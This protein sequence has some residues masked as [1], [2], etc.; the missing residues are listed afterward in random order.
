MNQTEL[1]EFFCWAESVAGFETEDC[2]ES[3]H[4]YFNNVMVGGWAGDC[5]QF[6]LKHNVQVCK[7][8]A[9]YDAR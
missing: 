8:I 1:D 4:Y 3:E 7:L 5:R 6:F 2:D 9:L